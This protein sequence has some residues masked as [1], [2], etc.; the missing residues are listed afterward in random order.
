MGE[1]LQNIHRLVLEAVRARIREGV[2]SERRLARI[3]GY[4]QP[5]VHN[6]LAGKRGLNAS[7]ADALLAAASLTL[8]EVLGRGAAQGPTLGGSIA[9]PRLEGRLGAGRRFPRLPSRPRIEHFPAVALEGLQEILLAEVAAGDDSMYPWLWPGDSVLIETDRSARRNPR[10]ESIYA[11][12]LGETGFLARCRRLGSRL[13][14]VVD[15]E[16]AGPTPPRWIDLEEVDVLNVV[17]GRIV[18][19]GR[20]LD[21]GHIYLA[22]PSL[23][24]EP[25]GR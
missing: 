5:H 17:R 6:V 7:T 13:L 22:S 20:R 25:D 16:T 23:Q 9:V 21:K 2:V 11:L 1:N 12:A 14:T 18:W 4:S 15:S 24:S 8:D 3:A 10:F 19:S